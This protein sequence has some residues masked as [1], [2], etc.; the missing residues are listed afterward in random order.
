VPKAS[1]AAPHQHRDQCPLFQFEFEADLDTE[2]VRFDGFDSISDVLAQWLDGVHGGAQALGQR[3]ADLVLR[4]VLPGLYI[5]ADTVEGNRYPAD[6]VI[7]H[8][9]PRGDNSRA[10]EPPIKGAFCAALRAGARPRRGCTA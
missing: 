10:N 3:A 4:A 5:K 1:C 8:G 7:A 9:P 2:M 6:I